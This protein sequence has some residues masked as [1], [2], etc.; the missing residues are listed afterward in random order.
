MSPTLEAQSERPDVR[1]P[2][3]PRSESNS[4][5][6]PLCLLNLHGNR[7]VPLSTQE[8]VEVPYGAGAEKSVEAPSFFNSTWSMLAVM[9]EWSEK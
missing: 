6:H 8:S 2:A 9:L 7:C 3:D 5:K 4:R 1:S